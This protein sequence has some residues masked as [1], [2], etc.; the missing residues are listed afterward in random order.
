MRAELQ[1]RIDERTARRFPTADP[2]FDPAI[3]SADNFVELKVI[4]GSFFVM[5]WARLA[6]PRRLFESGLGVKG[7]RL[8]PP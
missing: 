4:A 5:A 6:Q 1:L 2:A 3:A 8:A 7:E